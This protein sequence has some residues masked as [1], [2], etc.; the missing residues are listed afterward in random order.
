MDA[1]R[2]LE[3]RESIDEVLAF[4]E[5][6]GNTSDRPGDLARADLA[7]ASYMKVIDTIAYDLRQTLDPQQAKAL[8]RWLAQYS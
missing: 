7:K 2:Y 1:R 4:I 8:R 6:T 3:L 5:S